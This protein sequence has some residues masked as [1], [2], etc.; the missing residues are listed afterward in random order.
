[1]RPFLTTLALALCFAVQAT[2]QHAPN[3]S[4]DVRDL[5]EFE[6]QPTKIQLLIAQAL[7]LTKRDL[8]YTFGSDDP[9][10]GGMDCSG[11]IYHVLRAQGLKDVPRDSQ[12]QYEWTRGSGSYREVTART[13]DGPEF[14]DLRPGDLMFWSGTYN[15][16]RPGGGVSHVMMYLGTEKKT[17]KRV[18]FGASDGRTYNGVQRYGVS[19]FDFKMPRPEQTT[20]DFL[21]YAPIPGLPRGTVVTPSSTA[22]SSAKTSND[23]TPAPKTK[24][25]S[26]VAAAESETPKPKTKT[27]A[28]KPEPDAA[29]SETP[30][31]KSKAATTESGTPK[32][33]T[34]KKTAAASSESESAKSKS[35][36][37]ATD[38]DD[39]P[40]S[41]TSKKSGTAKTKSETSEPDAATP[42][43]KS[44]TQTPKPESE[45]PK[46]ATTKPKSKA[47]AD[48]EPS[49]SK[50]QS[51]TQKSKSAAEKSPA[52]STDEESEAPSSSKSKASKSA[53]ETPKPKA[54]FQPPQSKADES[55]DEQKP[56]SRTPKPKSKTRK[57]TSETSSVT[58]PAFDPR[59][60]SFDS[61][62]AGF[63]CIPSSPNKLCCSVFSSSGPFCPM[64]SSPLKIP[65]FST[66]IAFA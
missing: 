57:A 51:Q 50:S 30:K 26:A 37:S 16:G 1:M 12:S 38:S 17:G 5:V 54:G 63:N 24:K 32:P 66:M 56:K 3:A 6:D 34:K 64:N 58:L 60:S 23:E 49:A 31:P 47:A 27:T 52:K 53:S 41:A 40:K 18:M 14:A 25:K 2:A 21:G 42:K 13:A 22:K 33:G 36:A 59:P 39:T 10:N 35:E 28:A 44:K 4:L 15:T 29:D 46:S 19:V 7:A 61:P 45:D 55:E 65:P 11:T 43:P 9:A 8:G 62:Y 20:T 48:A